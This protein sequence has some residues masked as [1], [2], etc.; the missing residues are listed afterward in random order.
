[1]TTTKNKPSSNF[2][3]SLHRSRFHTIFYPLTLFYLVLVLYD[4][5]AIQTF[6]QNVNQQCS[7]VLNINTAFMIYVKSSFNANLTY[8]RE[9]ENGALLEVPHLTPHSV[10]YQIGSQITNMS[11]SYLFNNQIPS[12]LARLA[13]DNDYTELTNNFYNVVGYFD[14]EIQ[15]NRQ[16]WLD[17]VASLRFSCNIRFAFIVV[18]SAVYVIYLVYCYHHS[19]TQN[20]LVEAFFKFEKSDLDAKV[21][22]L[23]ECMVELELKC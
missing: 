8:V 23:R 11:S 19:K 20:K 18:E 22:H 14:N 5:I 2:N 16:E 3:P 6:D 13:L 7:S 15:Y 21:E 1:M 17:E 9:F 4:T 12:M 10:Q